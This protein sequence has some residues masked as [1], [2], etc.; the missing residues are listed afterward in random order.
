M[1]GGIED[2]SLSTVILGSIPQGVEMT[3]MCEC[4]VLPIFYLSIMR[5]LMGNLS[6]HF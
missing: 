5:R 6:H 3:V 4:K 2:R 1:L